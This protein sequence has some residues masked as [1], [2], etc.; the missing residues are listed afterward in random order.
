MM[1]KW[2]DLNEDIESLDYNLWLYEYPQK[3][4]QFITRLS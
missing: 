1:N 2:V 4:R 3:I